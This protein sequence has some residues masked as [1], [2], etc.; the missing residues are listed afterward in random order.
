MMRSIGIRKEPNFQRIVLISA[1]IHLILIILTFIPIKTGKREFKSYYVN[2][3]GPVEISKG[4]LKAHGEIQGVD[5]HPISKDT[6]T[7]KPIDSR[8]AEAITKEIERLRAIRELSRRKQGREEE[9]EIIRK[10]VNE[11]ATGIRGRRQDGGGVDSNSYY[12]IISEMI[13]SKW[14]FPDIESSGLEVIVSIRIDGK[15]NIL[16]QEIEKTSGN[17]LF[18]QSALRAISKANPLPPPP[19]GIET[20]VGVRFYL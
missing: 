4:G 12:A 15:G 16:S 1:T 19:M 8:K 11:E 3:V 7:T 10:R 13:W 18:D 6:I 20:E 5:R 17:A 14:V 2:L 9:V